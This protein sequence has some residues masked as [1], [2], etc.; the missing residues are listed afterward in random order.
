M[1]WFALTMQ[2]TRLALRSSNR[3]SSTGKDE[4]CRILAHLLVGR[5]RTLKIW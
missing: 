5:L 4:V 2:L 1:Q 3:T